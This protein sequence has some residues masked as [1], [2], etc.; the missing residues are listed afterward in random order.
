MRPARRRTTSR[1]ETRSRRHCIPRCHHFAPASIL[2]PERSS[3]CC[4]LGR[5]RGSRS[6]LGAT[7]IG[8]AGHGRSRHCC[9]VPGIAATPGVVRGA[10]RQKTLRP[11]VSLGGVSGPRSDQA[12]SGTMMSPAFA[13][14]RGQEARGAETLVFRFGKNALAKTLAQC[15][16]AQYGHVQCLTSFA[17]CHMLRNDTRLPN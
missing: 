9:A 10:T 6:R 8:D 16:H 14:R 2:E 3:V 11:D 15:G 7:V 5:S 4:A 12:P 1:T 17:S 13:C